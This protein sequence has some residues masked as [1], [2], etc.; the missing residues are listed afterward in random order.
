MRR[1]GMQVTQAWK[2]AFYNLLDYLSAH[3]CCLRQS[4]SHF[5]EQDLAYASFFLG[6]KGG[7]LNSDVLYISSVSVV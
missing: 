4:R 6:E 1:R 7:G 2:F 5:L 3:L